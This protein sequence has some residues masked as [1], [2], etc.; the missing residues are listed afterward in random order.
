MT[1][2]SAQQVKELREKTG[3]G[4]MDC[5]KALEETQGNFEEAVDWL[6][7]K[8]LATAAKK[9]G[10]EAAEGVV[11]VK[12]S[13]N[14]AVVAEIN[15]ETDFSASNDNFKETVTKLIDLLFQNP[16][17][18]LEEF[19]SLSVDG[20]K[21]DEFIASKIAI[22]GENISI[23]RVASLSVKSGV[24][25]TYIH[26]AISEGMGKIAV[27]I[28]LEAEDSSV[29]E[30]LL[31]TAKQIAMHIAAQ[32]PVAL[33]SQSLDEDFVKREMAINEEK[34]RASG[35][36]ENVIQMMLQGARN[37]LN[38]DYTLLDQKFVM[39]GK[40]KVGDVVKDLAQSVG[41]SVNI[42]KFLRFELGEGIVKQA[43]NFAEEVAATAAA[44]SK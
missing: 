28:G 27:V 17:N 35:K 12:S 31:P 20:M 18:N 32:R 43:K 19:K 33:D 25:S 34:F 41:K 23:R 10:R 6:R 1:Q 22:I 4:M 44:S 37:K 14:L 7:K 13:G 9:S 39:D 16:T 26:N 5:K 38:E 15:I 3:S 8:G 30:R 29:N 21:V 40:T 42:N 11:A 24:I 2:I 36:P